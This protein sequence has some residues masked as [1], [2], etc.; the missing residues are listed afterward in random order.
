M[1]IEMGD[2]IKQT[3]RGGARGRE[4]LEDVKYINMSA[5]TRSH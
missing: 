1:F 3:E 4:D 2:N 5:F